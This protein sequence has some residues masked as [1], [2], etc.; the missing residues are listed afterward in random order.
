MCGSVTIL[1]RDNSTLIYKDAKKERIQ[2]PAVISPDKQLAAVFK[3][4][5]KGGGIWD[6]TEY[7]TDIDLLIVTLD[8]DHK[9]CDIPVMPMPRSQFAF[10][11]ASNSTLIV[12]ND[13]RISAYK[14]LCP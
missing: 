12:L 4:S 2:P 6:T 11:F 5:F 1:T 9:A 14:R 7:R 3:Y 13:G 10:N 8:G